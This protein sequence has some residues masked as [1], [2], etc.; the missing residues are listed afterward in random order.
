MCAWYRMILC[1]IAIYCMICLKL[2]EYVWHVTFLSVCGNQPKLCFADVIVGYFILDEYDDI[3]GVQPCCH[4]SLFP[5]FFRP[6]SFDLP[7]V[8]TTSIG[9]CQAQHNA[10]VFLAQSLQQIA[11]AHVGPAWAALVGCQCAQSLLC[12]ARK[13]F[14]TPANWITKYHPQDADSYLTLLRHF[15]AG[16]ELP[17]PVP[18]GFADF[19]TFFVKRNAV[20]STGLEDYTSAVFEWTLPL[21][22]N[23]SWSQS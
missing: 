16:N 21:P 12:E 10:L 19:G 4:M 18:G 11:V 23:T 8:L 20:H 17:W 9:P 3:I 22:G 15:A 13:Y 2:F 5:I 14:D 6:I 1:D 7:S